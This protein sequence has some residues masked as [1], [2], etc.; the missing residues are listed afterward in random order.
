MVKT[1]LS[2]PPAFVVV[3]PYEGGGAELNWKHSWRAEFVAHTG[4][5][6]PKYQNP[7]LE[8]LAVASRV[9]PDKID[10]A[11]LRLVEPVAPATALAKPLPLRFSRKPLVERQDCWVLGYPP[12][13]S[14]TPTPVPVN[15]AN[16]DGNALKVTG[17][18]IMP[19]HSG[20]PLVTK[21]GTVVG[22]NFARNNELS[23]CRP[24]AAAEQCIRLVLPAP[25]AWEQLLASAEAEDAHD[26]Q[27]QRAENA[28]L[29]AGFDLY[30]RA[31]MEALKGD[32]KRP[33]AASS[34]DSGQGPSPPSDSRSAG[35]T[36]PVS[37]PC[38]P[39]LDPA[40]PKEPLFG[41]ED[42]EHKLKEALKS[43]HRYYL[44]LGAA[45]LG[46]TAIV[47]SVARQLVA[48]GSSGSRFSAIVFV[49]LRARETEDAV[50]SAV[51]DAIK[52]AGVGSSDP[53]TLPH[54]ALL[55]L[56]NADDPYKLKNDD[57]WFEKRILLELEKLGCTIL[58]T[59]RYA[60]PAHINPLHFGPYPTG[61]SS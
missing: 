49:E 11:I 57:G 28:R 35:A 13:G 8:E 6:D 24:I 44:V 18:Q 30:H 39:L 10:L 47:K 36:A 16:M 38:S 33:T 48:S 53:M 40:H 59:M 61:P 43:D 9:L 45:G 32:D 20:G 60:C 37:L 41:R 56:D 7:V 34:S 23:W 12:A 58:M 25:D 51:R 54:E 46:K 26:R 15:F 19:G 21:S 5:G 55:I 29:A 22:W 14:T 50:R 1:E 17:A 2:K 27:Q 42:D 31:G 52:T 3:C 4:I